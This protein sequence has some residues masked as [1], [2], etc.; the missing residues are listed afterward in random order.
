MRINKKF[1]RAKIEKK[2]LA[3]DKTWTMIDEFHD[4][5]CVVLE[6]ELA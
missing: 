3:D 1:L 6:V 4:Y 5:Y 2:V